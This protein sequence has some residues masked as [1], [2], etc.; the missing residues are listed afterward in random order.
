MKILNNFDLVSFQKIYFLS[1][2]LFFA[3]FK[4]LYFDN[5]YILAFPKN[6]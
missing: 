1:L 5:K 3:L 2:Y 6:S 4:N